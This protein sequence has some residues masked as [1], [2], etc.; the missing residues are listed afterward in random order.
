MSWDR[1]SQESLL[2]SGVDLV[3]FV[4]IPDPSPALDVLRWIEHCNVRSTILAVI[5][6]DLGPAGIDLVS[7][8]ADDFI[9]WPEQR[10]ILR[11]RIGRLLDF[12][13]EEE[14]GKAYQNLIRE[15]GRANLMGGDPVFLRVAEQLAACAQSVFPVLVTG[16]TGTGKEMFARAIHFLSERRNHPFIPMDCAGLPDHL[17]ENELFGHVR[18]AYTDAHSEQRGLAAL[19]HGGTLFLD[20]VDS[21]SHAAQG[22]LLRF[23]QERQFKPL[24]SERF[25]HSDVKI[26]SASNRD[27]EQHTAV[28]QFRADLYYRLKVLHLDL[29]P[30]RDRPQD[31]DL[32]ARHFLKMYLPVGVHK[33]FSPAALR[34]LAAYHWPGNVRELVNVVQQAITFSKGAQINGCDISVQVS[35]PPPPASFRQVRERTIQSFERD[36]IYQLLQ[37]HAGNITHAARE[38]GK[39][40]RAFGRLVK[41]YGL[42]AQARTPGCD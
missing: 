19:A 4:G 26:I 6:R 14:V 20:E 30:L 27:L 31:I 28:K 13:P 36:Y 41:K 11:Q 21:L 16:E 29:P 12:G 5:P 10:E 8:N 18:G 40:R 7:T 2:H 33:S 38:A 15:L 39:E 42:A 35:A 22:K 3:V 9:L 34:R 25:V 17:I 37:R 1:F 23:L 24:G 32:L